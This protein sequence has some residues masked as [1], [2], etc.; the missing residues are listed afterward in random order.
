M[1]VS[2]ELM[3]PSYILKMESVSSSET[4]VLFYRTLQRC[5][6]ED[7]SRVIAQP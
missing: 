6:P 7:G 2:E 5:I 1:D 4:L 3:I